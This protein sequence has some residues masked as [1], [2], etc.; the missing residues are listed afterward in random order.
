MLTSLVLDWLHHRCDVLLLGDVVSYLS[1]RQSSSGLI[2]TLGTQN[3]W[4][5][6]QQEFLIL[7]FLLLYQRM[8]LEHYQKGFLSVLRIAFF[9]T[10]AEKVM[11]AGFGISR[12]LSLPPLVNFNLLSLLKTFSSRGL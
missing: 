8:F 3:Y 12:C 10:K 7:N 6:F 4:I 9:K 5:D 11:R 2:N 1:G